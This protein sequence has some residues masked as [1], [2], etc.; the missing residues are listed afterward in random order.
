M[1]SFRV[2]G[3]HVRIDQAFTM[4]RCSATLVALSLLA[5]VGTLYSQDQLRSQARQVRSEAYY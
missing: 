4:A 2:L 1:L 5:A 3:R